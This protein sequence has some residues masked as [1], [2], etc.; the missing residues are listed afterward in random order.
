MKES[1]IAVLIVTPPQCEIEGLKLMDRS[2]R[3]GGLPLVRF[4][5]NVA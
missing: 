5:R 4:K 3:M 1:R 2:E